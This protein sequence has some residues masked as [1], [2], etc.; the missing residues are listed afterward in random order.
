M[1]PGPAA[2]KL[3]GSLAMCIS[4]RA[5]VHLQWRAHA[6]PSRGMPTSIESKLILTHKTRTHKKPICTSVV[7]FTA[8]QEANAFICSMSSTS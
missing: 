8:A 3:S 2:T 7:W 6:M 5:H 4:W 1:L